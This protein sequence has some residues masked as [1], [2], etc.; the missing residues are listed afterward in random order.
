MLEAQAGCC[1]EAALKYVSIIAILAWLFVS[2]TAIAGLVRSF[3]AFWRQR[4]KN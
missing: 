4:G 1:Q 3:V 2:L